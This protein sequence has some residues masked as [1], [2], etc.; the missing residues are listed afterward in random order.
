M[1]ETALIQ[2][3]RVASDFKAETT[4]GPIRF[5][6]WLGLPWGVLFGHPAE[7]TPVCTTEPGGTA[8]PSPA[9]SRPAPFPQGWEVKRPYLRYVEVTWGSHAENRLRNNG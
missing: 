6:E 4:H 1:R 9:T 3:G 8:R 5:D 2:L 7:F